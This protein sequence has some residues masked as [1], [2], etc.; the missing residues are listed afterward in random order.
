MKH[1]CSPCAFV[2]ETEDT[3]LRL[4]D[5]ALEL[6]ITVIINANAIDADA[7]PPIWRIQDP[8]C[9]FQRRRELVKL[10]AKLR[11]RLQGYVTATAKERLDRQLA[12]PESDEIPF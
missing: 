10:A 2:F 8:R 12:L 9:P 11:R 3:T 5:R 1:S 7:P 4:L 6:A